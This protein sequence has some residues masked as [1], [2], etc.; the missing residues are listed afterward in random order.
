MYFSLILHIDN[1]ILKKDKILDL[2]IS[3]LDSKC[4]FSVEIVAVG[5]KQQKK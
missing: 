5:M 1:F 2:K 4:Y 3:L